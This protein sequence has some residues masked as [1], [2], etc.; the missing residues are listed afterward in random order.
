[1]AGKNNEGSKMTEQRR[2]LMKEL[3]ALE[4]VS[5]AVK[6]ARHQERLYPIELDEAIVSEKPLTYSRSKLIEIMGKQISD[7]LAVLNEYINEEISPL[8]NLVE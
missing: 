1:M 5:Q 4:K 7:D 2:F 6:N 8:F 3:E